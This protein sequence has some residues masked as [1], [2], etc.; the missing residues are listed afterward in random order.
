MHTVFGNIKCESMMC[1]RNPKKTRERKRFLLKVETGIAC[2]A[3]GEQKMGGG[4][5]LSQHS[6]DRTEC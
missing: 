5:V 2:S 1:Y 6:D 3:L 4:G